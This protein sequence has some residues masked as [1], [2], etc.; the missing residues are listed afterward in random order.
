MS[1]R[2][3]NGMDNV[4]VTSD[5]SREPDERHSER[6]SDRERRRE[7]TRRRAAEIGTNDGDVPRAG[8]H[9]GG[10]IVVLGKRRKEE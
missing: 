2:K 9:G 6:E 3:I 1:A 10:R 5:R 7:K 4:S 8:G